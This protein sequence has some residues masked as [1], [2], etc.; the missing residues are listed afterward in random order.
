MYVVCRE[1]PAFCALV[2]GDGEVTDF[3]R[4]VHILKR[5]N[6][7]RKED[8]EGKESDMKKLKDFIATKKP[9]VIAVSAE[10]RYIDF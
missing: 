7:Y 1:E 3:L 5:R 8:R 9:H 6:A 2:D 4:L 10:A